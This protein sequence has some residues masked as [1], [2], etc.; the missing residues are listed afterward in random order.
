MARELPKLPSVRG[1]EGHTD[2]CR[3]R[4][5]SLLKDP[6]DNGLMR[7]WLLAMHER[8]TDDIEQTLVRELSCRGLELETIGK[9]HTG[10][11]N[12]LLST[13]AAW[14]DGI[15]SGIVYPVP[16]PSEAE[17]EESRRFYLRTRALAQRLSRIAVDR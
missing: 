5:H 7:D 6:V 3:R 2:R 11:R 9:V 4:I 1:E 15:L 17:A 12:Q 8:L 16:F 10:L 14:A 13:L